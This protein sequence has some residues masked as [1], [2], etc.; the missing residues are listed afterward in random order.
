MKCEGEWIGMSKDVDRKEVDEEA[1]V[2]RE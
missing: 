1:N 2:Q